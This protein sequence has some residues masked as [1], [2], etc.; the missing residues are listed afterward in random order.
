MNTPY[1]YKNAMVKKIVVFRKKKKKK[2]RLNHYI[3][4]TVEPQ[5]RSSEANYKEIIDLSNLMMYKFRKI[6]A[7]PKDNKF[8]LNGLS[9]R[10][11]SWTSK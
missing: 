1:V 9:K 3:Q 11:K 6:K 7:Q 10:K 5:A 8:S 2:I 4:L